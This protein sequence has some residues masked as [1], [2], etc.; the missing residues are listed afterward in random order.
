M[1]NPKL[2]QGTSLAACAGMAVLYVVILYVPQSLLR[3]PPA[4]TVNEYYL[5][6]FLS[7]AVA[8]GLASCCAS[9]SYR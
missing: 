1:A 6:R 7:S 8:S 5:R 2:S 4:R 3:L 9:Y